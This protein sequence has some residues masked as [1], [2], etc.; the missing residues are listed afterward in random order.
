MEKEENQKNTNLDENKELGAENIKSEE[1]SQSE[2]NQEINQKSEE[3]TKE[4]TPEEKIK[5]INIGSKTMLLR[6]FIGI[7]MEI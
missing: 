4:L 5:V 2:D 1:N 3:E 7:F 6:W